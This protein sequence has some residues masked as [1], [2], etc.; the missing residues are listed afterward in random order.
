MDYYDADGAHFG[1]N[2]K[3]FSNALYSLTINNFLGDNFVDLVMGLMDGHMA[4]MSYWLIISFLNK[5]MLANFIC[6]ILYN[7]YN[8]LFD[9][10]K[11]YM[12]RP[13]FTKI[14][15]SLKREIANENLKGHVFDNIMRNYTKLG[16]FDKVNDQIEKFYSRGKQNE[17]RTMHGIDNPDNMGAHFNVL[18]HTKLYIFTLGLIE[19]FTYILII[20]TFEIDVEDTYYLLVLILIINVILILDRFMFLLNNYY[21]SE[22]TFRII[23]IIASL[24]IIG[25][26]MQ[27]LARPE[28]TYY[29]ELMSKNRNYLKYLCVLFVL[30]SA[31]FLRLFR[32]NAQIA[33]VTKVIFD[34]FAFL[35][36]ILG[37]IV[38]FFFLFGS[39][40]MSM[41]GGNVNSSTPAAFEE[42]YG[43]E[44]DELLMMMNFNDYYYAILTLF[45]VMMGGWTSTVALNTAAFGKEHQS[46]MY[47]VFF[48]IYFFFVNLCFLNTL[49]GFLVDN[50]SA[51]LEVAME[52][53]QAEKEAQSGDED[54]S[55]A[56]Q[57][58]ESDSQKPKPDICQ[59]L[60]KFLKLK[61]DSQADSD[62]LNL[63]KKIPGFGDD[64][65]QYDTNYDPVQKAISKVPI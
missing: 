44:P 41:F 53:D 29:G 13:M 24:C 39:L 6:G 46:M 1:Y 59:E 16:D 50:V 32:Y 42:I 56:S 7:C 19:G 14:R 64:Q 57:K 38:I 28:A 22:T 9:K 10:D 18:R 54:G 37:I 3:S 27:C 51:N 43:D 21:D 36:D 62:D 34:S 48:L 40:G 25:L 45:T 17:F 61:E 58:S 30:K 33:M 26:G 4:L 55:M 49:F 60:D 20:I 11:A 15:H 23:D 5:F 47:N 31:R 52:A 65:F 8:I 63:T 12:R 35:T 2:F